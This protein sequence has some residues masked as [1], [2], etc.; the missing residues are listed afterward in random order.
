[1]EETAQLASKAKMELQGKRVI[2]VY[3]GPK[4]PKAREV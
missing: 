2:L 3:K 4:G 1:V